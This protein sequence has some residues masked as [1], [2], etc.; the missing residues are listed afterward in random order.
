MTELYTTKQ[1]FEAKYGKAPKKMVLDGM[2][3][4]ITEYGFSDDNNIVEYKLVNFEKVGN[5]MKMNVKFVTV[6]Y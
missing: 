5:G 3:Y 6:E 4:D 1:Q 2:T